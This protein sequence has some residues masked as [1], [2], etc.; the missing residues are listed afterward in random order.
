MTICSQFLIALASQAVESGERRGVLTRADNL[1][2][3]IRMPG[4]VWKAVIRW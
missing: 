4:D 1:V 2:T 3:A